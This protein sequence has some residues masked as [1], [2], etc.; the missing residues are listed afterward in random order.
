MGIGNQLEV[1]GRIA[2]RRILI[3]PH[4]DRKQLY[5]V[6][7]LPRPLFSLPLMGIGNPSRSW[8]TPG[9]TIT[10][11][12]SWGSETSAGLFGWTG[13][14]TSLPLMGIGNPVASNAGVSISGAHYPSW[15]SETAVAVVRTEKPF[16]LITPHGDRKLRESQRR[17]SVLLDSL[18]LMGIGNSRTSGTLARAASAHYPSWGSETPGRSARPRSSSRL[19]TPHGDRKP[20]ATRPRPPCRTPPH[21]PSWGSETHPQRALNAAWRLTSLPLMGIGNHGTPHVHGLRP[22]SLP[23][24]GIGNPNRR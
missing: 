24:M 20:G 17:R 12:P 3:T 13:P 18:P 10:H 19:I 21:Y 11:Y 6:R 9:A 8:C 4:G 1:A 22:A 14:S 5:L 16:A 7:E 23:L 15:G 2:S